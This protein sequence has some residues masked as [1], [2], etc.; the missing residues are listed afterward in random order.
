[1]DSSTLVGGAIGILI[2]LVLIAILVL[3]FRWLWNST[4]P[5]VFGIKQLTFWQ[6]LKILILAGIL[7]GGYRIA[8]V[9]KQISGGETPA[10]ATAD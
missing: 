4:M 9:P 7:F 6:A 10:A 2:A 3:I 5:E 8:E 1:M